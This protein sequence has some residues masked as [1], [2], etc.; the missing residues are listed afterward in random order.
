MNTTDFRQYA[1]QLAD[2]MADYMENIES[3]PVMSQLS[4]GETSTRLPPQAPLQAEP[5]QDLMRDFA[6]IIMPGIT[7]WQHPSFFAYFP[8]NSS[9]PSILA[10]M[11]TATLAVQG[12]VWQTSP[13]ATELEEVVIKWLVQMLGLPSDFTGLIQD[14][15]SSAT[16][17]SLLSARERASHL[18]VNN[19]GFTPKERY[20]CYCS[21]EAHSSVEKAVKISGIGKINLRRISVDK[22]MAM[23]PHVLKKVIASDRQLGYQPLWAVATLGT[24]GSTAI[25]PLVEIADICR[26]EGLWLH[27]DAALAGTALILPEMRWMAKG[28]EGIDSFV[29]NPHKWMF[30]NFDCS[31]YLVRDPASLVQ[32]FE[33][34]P[35]YLKTAVD[36]RVNNYRDWG[37]QLGRR[38]RALKLWFVIR[39]YGIEGLQKIIRSHIALAARLAREIDNH[40]DFSLLAPVPLNTVC[41]RY[42]PMNVA[43]ENRIDSL[44]QTLLETLNKSG[45][46]YITHTRLQGKYTLRLVVGQTQ[47]EWRHVSAAWELIKK[48]AKEIFSVKT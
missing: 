29:F 45:K 20:S 48:T 37:I 18:A 2:W 35:E 1:H 47:V 26:T 11:L 17:C 13:A 44:N 39:S 42:Q 34:T 24:T 33:I 19:S 38:F 10:E 4:P 27:V 36:N 5:F 6:D 41:F 16:L 3:Y 14:S 15:A 32:T 43:D 23:E 28:I 25:D 22:S 9:P 40:P 30:T 31:I 12:M 21:E 46:I 8:A 7:H